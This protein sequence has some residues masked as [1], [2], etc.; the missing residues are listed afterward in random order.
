MGFTIVFAYFFF[1]SFSSFYV[2][3][4]FFSIQKVKYTSYGWYVDPQVDPVNSVIV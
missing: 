1:F 2:P 3:K 4:D